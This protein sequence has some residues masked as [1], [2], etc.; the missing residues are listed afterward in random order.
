MP[1]R[2]DLLLEA[3]R[4]GIEISP[5]DRGLMSE[6]RRRGMAPPPPGLQSLMGTIRQIQ[7]G[8]VKGEMVRKAQEIGAQV[9]PAVPGS[10]MTEAPTPKP[11]ALPFRAAVRRQ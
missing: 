7:P 6:A 2:L 5:E 3:E 1:T 4:R 11:D 8:E 10:P 9:R